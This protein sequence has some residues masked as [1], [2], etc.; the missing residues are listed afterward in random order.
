[1]VST[2]TPV[3]GQI[4]DAARDERT[5]ELT[6]ENE[7]LRA[8]TAFILEE[9][10]ATVATYL[11]A[12]GDPV[13]RESWRWDDNLGAFRSQS[14]Y[15]DRNDRLHGKSYPLF[16][17][18]FELAA[19]RGASR[20]LFD[21]S[22]HTTNIV[23]NLLNF[24]VAQGYTYKAQ[25]KRKDM[26]ELV[27]EVQWVIDEFLERNEWQKQHG[28]REEEIITRA[29]RDGE[30]FV[31]LFDPDRD[32]FATIRFIEPD[33]ITKPNDPAALADVASQHN[34]Y[35]PESDWEFGIHCTE[36]DVEDIHGYCVQWTNDSSDV[37]YIPANRLV[38]V[39]LNVD[40]AIKR[41]ISSYYR[42]QEY[43]T[44]IGKLEK[45]VVKGAAIL[46]A[47]LGVRQHAAGTTKSDVESL[48]SSAMYRRR[49]ESTVDNGSRT[50]NV[51]RILAGTWLDVS[52]GLEYKPSPLATQGVGEAFVAIDQATLRTI[53]LLYQMPEYMVSGD[54]SNS[55]FASSM[56][57]EAPVVKRFSREQ[58]LFGG[59]ELKIMWRMIRLAVDGR[60]F[61]KR[62]PG[63]TYDDIRRYV[64]I[65]VTGPRVA[66]RDANVETNRH[67]ILFDSGQISGRTWSEME[68]LDFDKEQER[69]A[70]V[71][72]AILAVQNEPKAP[73][74]PSVMNESER[75]QIAAHL[76]WEGYPNA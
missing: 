61:Q 28:C 6:E 19:I 35:V 25:A 1:M 27:D 60:R 56:V 64:S 69:G 73:G 5:R 44:S 37:D 40:R 63:M 71:N 31:A 57:A 32:G 33:Q 26:Q 42:V 67:K 54:A 12:W 22:P 65:V 51:Q 59:D 4:L 62:F 41:G 74:R 47:I 30:V 45:N 53:G 8:Q 20:L 58:S 21:T 17:T 72:S 70:K 75:R 3:R 36:G 66:A 38:H 16:E 76:L 13:E 68:G 9:A 39:K 46:S 43:L 50:R 52:K 2:E 24:I 48:L 34:G 23:E 14:P 49:T 7:R 15:S 55:N 29:V 10:A 11:E 18:E